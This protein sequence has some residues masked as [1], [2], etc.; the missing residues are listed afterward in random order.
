[1]GVGRG[2]VGFNYSQTETVLTLIDINGDGL[3]DKLFLSDRIC[4]T[5]S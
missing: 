1:V 5:G 2:Q 3:L 4:T